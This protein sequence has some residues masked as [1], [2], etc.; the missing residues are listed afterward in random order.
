MM[1]LVLAAVAGG[2]A[3]TISTIHLGA[4]Q[5]FLFF[6]AGGNAAALAAAAWLFASR[7]KI[8]A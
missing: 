1:L 7:S 3:A 8:W 5:P 4:G 2:L 6:F